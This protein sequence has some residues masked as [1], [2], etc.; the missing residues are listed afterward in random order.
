MYCYTCGKPIEDNAA[1]CPYCG[2]AIAERAKETDYNSN[3]LYQL[4]PTDYRKYCL[5]VY[6]DR[7][8]IDGKFLY[9]KDKEFI[10]QNG[11]VTALLHNY[12]GMGYLAKRSYRKTFAFVFG[13]VILGVINSIIEKFSA[14]ADKANSF[15]RW[16]GE[17]VTLPEWMTY[18]LNGTMVICIILGILLFFS[19]KKVVEISFTDKRICIPRRSLSDAEY[20]GLYQTIK[21]LSNKGKL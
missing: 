5:K 6:Q 16:I 21:N 14:L 7:I 18:L 4:L 19:K 11:N 15:L 8:T 20:A 9:L 12:I 10:A 1:Y 2:A 13:G 3:I 17:T